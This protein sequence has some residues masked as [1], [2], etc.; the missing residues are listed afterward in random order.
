MRLSELLADATC[1]YLRG[2]GDTEITSVDYSSRTV[3]PG[4]LFICLRGFHSDGHD[5]I[6]QAVE[7]L[8][9][10]HI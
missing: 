4:S 10:I 6:A 1:E 8:S 9:L 3:Q 7:A 5:Y 2:N